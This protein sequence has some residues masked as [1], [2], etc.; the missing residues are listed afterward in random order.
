[1]NF[2]MTNLI[3]QH[4]K[5]LMAAVIFLLA[6]V[7]TFMW[8]WTRWWARDSYYSHGI[9]IPFV[10]IFLIWQIKDELKAVPRQ[11]S[12]WAVWLI[13]LGIGIHLL[14]SLFRVYFTSGFSMLIVL[15]GLI[16]YF[17]GWAVLKKI[18]FP[19]FFLVFMLPLP[20]VLIINISFKLKL[21]A[22]QLATSVLNNLGILA[23]QEGSLIKM[24]HA[25]VV[26]EDVCSGLRSLISLG[27]LGSIFAYWLKG[28]MA[29]KVFLFLTTIPIAIVTNMCR[30]VILSVISEVWGA[31]YATSIV[32]DITG[33]SVF[34]LAFIMLYAVT[35]V[36]E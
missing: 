8:M 36:I 7:P 2:T 34:A 32:H 29:K 17:Y 25:Q 19:I 4:S 14:S 26:V 21:F 22:A 1:M 24:R 3:K 5:P 35:K 15:V 23:I 20:E 30:V 33:F 16:L 28:S 27:A 11:E 9:L 10:T 13:G 31:E 6:Y 18:L 12:P